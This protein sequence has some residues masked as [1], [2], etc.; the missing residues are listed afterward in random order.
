MGLNLNDVIVLTDDTWFSYPFDNQKFFL[1]STSRVA[2]LAFINIPIIAILLN[3][4][5]Q[6]VSSKAH[7][8]TL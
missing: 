1:N 4:L 5:R 2:L 6:L 8:P 3:V 7:S